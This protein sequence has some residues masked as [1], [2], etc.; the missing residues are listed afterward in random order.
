[1][2]HQEDHDKDSGSAETAASAGAFGPQKSEVPI[3]LDDLVAFAILH[4]VVKVKPRRLRNRSGS[5]RP[6]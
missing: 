5:R 4:S 2:K 1:M 6:K 3:D